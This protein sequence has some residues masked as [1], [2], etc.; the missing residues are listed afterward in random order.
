MNILDKIVDS[1]IEYL[2][3]RKREYPL[4]KI[5]DSIHYSRKTLSLTSALTDNK[6]GIISEFKRKSPSVQNI[7]LG[8]LIDDVI[9]KYIAGNTSGISVLTDAYFNGK[10][11]DLLDARKISNKPLLR[12]DFILTEYQVH[13]AKALGADAILLIAYCLTKDKVNELTELA[14]NLDLEVLF[15]IHDFTEMTKMPPSVDIL[16]VNN[17]NLT[18][19][20][21]DY[22]YAISLMEKLPKDKCKIS[23]SGIK[24]VE[25][26]VET[27]NAGFNGC[28]IGEFLMKE[29]NPTLTIQTLLNSI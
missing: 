15:E 24:S 19:F 20:E 16:G 22:K 5:K 2:K 28:L 13:E 7:N 3:E 21:V 18:T 25:Q 1:K 8:G 26:Y 17:R 12:K 27:I 11:Q 23:E 29:N 4:S 14:H 10:E 9:P 6:A